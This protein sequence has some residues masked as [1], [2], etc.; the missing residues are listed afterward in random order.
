MGMQ[1]RLDYTA[2]DL[3]V[4]ATATRESADSKLGCEYRA[5]I[6]GPSLSEPIDPLPARVQNYE[7]GDEVV[8]QGFTQAL[9]ALREQDKA[10]D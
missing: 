10:S 3:R 7:N 9:E 4:V 8:G 6:T 2:P 5:L 1:P